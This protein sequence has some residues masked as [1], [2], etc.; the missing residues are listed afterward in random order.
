MEG[1]PLSFHL[2][3]YHLVTLALLDDLGVLVEEMHLSHFYLFGGLDVEHVAVVVL[4]RVC[5]VNIISLQV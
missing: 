1:F 4:H 2:P 3:E 5:G